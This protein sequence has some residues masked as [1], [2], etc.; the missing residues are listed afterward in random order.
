MVHSLID[1]DLIGVQTATIL[2]WY[3]VFIQEGQE[4]I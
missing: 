2:T 4:S 3:T 1:M